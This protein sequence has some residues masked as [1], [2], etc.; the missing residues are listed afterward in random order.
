VSIIAFFASEK[1]EKKLVLC[2]EYQIILKIKA[3][4]HL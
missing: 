3:K 4:I 2:D 1:M